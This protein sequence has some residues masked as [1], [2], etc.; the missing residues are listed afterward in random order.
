MNRKLKEER[1]IIQEIF[2]HEKWGEYCWRE[3]IEA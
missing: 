2:E 3:I 1:E